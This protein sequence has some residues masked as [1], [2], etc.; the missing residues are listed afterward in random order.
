MWVRWRGGKKA[1]FST[2]QLALRAASVEMTVGWFSEER[3]RQSNG[4]GVVVG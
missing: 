4:N 2:A 3:Q 1:D